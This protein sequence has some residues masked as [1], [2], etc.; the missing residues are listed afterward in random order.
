MDNGKLNQNYDEKVV[1][2]YMKNEN[3]DLNIEI[4]TGIKNFTAFTMDLTNEY[5]NINADYRS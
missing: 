4:S 3:I 2:N 5:I 1:A